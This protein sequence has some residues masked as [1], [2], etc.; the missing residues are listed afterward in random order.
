MEKVEKCKKKKKGKVKNGGKADKFCAVWK[1]MEKFE[2]FGKVWKRL[3]LLG[4]VKKCWILWEKLE[5]IDFF[6]T[7]E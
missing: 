5:K 7:V 4:N 6:S 2:M 1:S 3:E